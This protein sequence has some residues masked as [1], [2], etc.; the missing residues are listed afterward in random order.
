MFEKLPCV[1][2]A[3]DDHRNFVHRLEDE[4][5]A[6]AGIRHSAQGDAGDVRLLA[7]DARQ[8]RQSAVFTLLADV[9]GM[10]GRIAP[11]RVVPA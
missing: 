1:N 11:S 3:A 6:V 8:L 2:P 5:H 4:P 9:S 10:N 7:H